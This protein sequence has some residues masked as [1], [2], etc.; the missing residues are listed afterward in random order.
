M[1]RSARVLLTFGNTEKV[2]KADR[3]IGRSESK[4]LLRQAG[5]LFPLGS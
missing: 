5:V 3:G 1:T 2:R 4:A